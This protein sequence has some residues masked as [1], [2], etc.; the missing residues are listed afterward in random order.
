LGAKDPVLR[1]LSAFEQGT[2]TVSDAT[3]HRILELLCRSRVRVRQG[4]STTWVEAPVD[5][6]DLSSEYIGILYEGLLDFEL[7]QAIESPI[8]FL[9]LGDQPALL[10]ERL[11]NM[12]D[13]DLSSLV[14]KLKQKSSDEEEIEE[15]TVEEIEEETAAI[16]EVEIESDDR[17]Q[18]VRDRALR[19][20]VRAVEAGKLVAKPRSKKIDAVAQYERSVNAAAQA[21]LAR[22]VLPGEWFLVRWGGTRKGAGTFYT[23]P[24]LAVPTTRMVLHPLVYEGEN[25]RTP[26]EIL[27]SMAQS[28]PEWGI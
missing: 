11:E 2:H 19:W 16:E 5:F 24:Q 14:E 7:R 25:P 1:S 18:Q 26:E 12:T 3:V 9:N 4:R 23:R 8:V 13:A 6:S 28:P 21:L 10:L 22:I 17:V 20:A 15:E 27:A